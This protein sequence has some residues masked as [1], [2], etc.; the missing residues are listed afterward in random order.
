MKKDN[1]NHYCKPFFLND[2]DKNIFIG[3]VIR[4]VDFSLFVKL[5]DIFE[6][7]IIIYPKKDSYYTANKN[8]LEPNNFKILGNYTLVID[9]IED[10]IIM[11]NL[12]KGVIRKKL[13]ENY[14]IDIEFSII[15]MKNN[16]DY[17]LSTPYIKGNKDYLN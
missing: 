2:I 9:K 17:I 12:K 11:D 3:Q 6:L 14:D 15:I 8:N 13:N 4:D 10:L 16:T 7:S 5:N 1:V